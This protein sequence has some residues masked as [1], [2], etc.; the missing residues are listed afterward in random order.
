MLRRKF[1]HIT[2]LFFLCTLNS[3]AI[4]YGLITE[5]ILTNKDTNYLSPAEVEVSLNRLKID[6]NQDYSHTLPSQHI[7]ITS[8]DHYYNNKSEDFFEFIGMFI[9]N[10]DSKHNIKLKLK[11]TRDAEFAYG[12]FKYKLYF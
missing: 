3:Y 8:D 5:N 4:E 2:Y 1:L 10:Y 6:L 11:F 7:N 9:S 12:F